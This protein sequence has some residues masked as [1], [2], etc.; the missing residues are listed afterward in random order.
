[1]HENR[2]SLDAICMDKLN[3]VLKVFVQFNSWIII[4]FHYFVVKILWIQRTD[5]ISNG[6]N[7]SDP[8]ILQTMFVDR[9]LL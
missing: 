7:M 3:A 5:A 4:H 9:I 8:N 1:M 2:T 6:K